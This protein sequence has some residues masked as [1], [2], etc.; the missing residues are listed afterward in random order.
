MNCDIQEIQNKLVDEI[1]MILSIE[2]ESIDINEPLHSMGLDSLSFVELL[3]SI[4]KNFNLKL[5]NT[6]LS[7][8]DFNTINSL[9]QRLFKVVHDQ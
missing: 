1:S 3:V 6:S 9:S 5:I 7:K 2:V 8:E 4:E